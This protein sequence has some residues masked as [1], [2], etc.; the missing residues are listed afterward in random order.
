MYGKPGEHIKKQGHHLQIEVHIVNDMAFPV[1]MCG[2]ERWT[3]K[4]V[5]C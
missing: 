2:C 3:I 5:E 4:K 1:I